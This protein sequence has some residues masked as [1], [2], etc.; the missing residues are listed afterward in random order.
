MQFRMV[1]LTLYGPALPE[2]P[3]NEQSSKL[4][5]SEGKIT[6]RAQRPLGC[7]LNSLSAEIHD[8]LRSQTIECF[9]RKGRG[10][11]LLLHRRQNFLLFQFIERLLKGLPSVFVSS[12]T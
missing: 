6:V 12:P 3:C 7:S 8:D 4:L 10:C 5:S 1:R 11:L 9:T 2:K